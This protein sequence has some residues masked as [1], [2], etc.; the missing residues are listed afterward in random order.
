M[1]RFFGDELAR[2]CGGTWKPRPPESVE[3]VSS[4]T[5]SLARGNL[6]VALKGPKFDGHDFLAAAFDK[7]AAGAVA[8]T[9]CGFPFSVRSPVL[10]VPDT[11]AALAA[12]AAG[13]RRSLDAEIVGVTGSVG[14]T[15]V[16][17]MTAA[18]L[19]SSMPVARTPGNWNNEVGLPLSLLAMERSHRAGVFEVGVSHPGEMAPLVSILRPSRAVVTNVGPV[20][21]EFFKTVEAVAAEKAR[22]LESL[23]PDGVAIL[24]KDSPWFDRM[25][26]AAP[27]RVVAVS[28]TADAD[29]VGDRVCYADET[30]TAVVRE[31]SSGDERGVRISVPGMHNLANALMAVAAAR[32]LGVSWD[33]IGRAL[34]EYRP[35]PLRWERRTVAAVTVINDAYNANPMSMRSAIETFR[36]LK[37]RGRKWLVLGGMLELGETSSQE[38]FTLGH[39]VGLGD[40][41]GLMVV[42]PLG[43]IVAEGAEKAGF[44]RER[45]VKCRDSAEA[46]RAMASLLQPGDAVLLKASRGV[47][48]EEVLEHWSRGVA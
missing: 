43:A 17:E 26:S 39:E 32:G 40:C 28:L 10:E 21:L 25:H 4:D 1:A 16:K 48:L 19:A 38:H 14:K 42:G 8:R 36:H 23:P 3:G 45:I 24:W 37:A 46:A 27:G 34:E 5:R 47:R 35:L 7:G 9:G 13:Y 29:Y 41:G 22:L 30:T 33:G 6:Y 11:A 15:T 12:L 20:H 44:D 2:W 18:M 31:A